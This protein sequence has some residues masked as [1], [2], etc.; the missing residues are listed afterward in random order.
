MAALGNRCERQAGCTPRA[1]DIRYG[2]WVM[3]QMSVNVLRTR[4]N[5]RLHLCRGKRLD[6]HRLRRTGRDN[7]GPFVDEIADDGGRIG[8]REPAKGR[9]ERFE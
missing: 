3:G 1:P 4:R 2:Q 8:R 9:L 6:L 7:V 5:E